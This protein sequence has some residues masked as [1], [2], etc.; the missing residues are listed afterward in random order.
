MRTKPFIIAVLSITS[1]FLVGH[2]AHS[3]EAPLGRVAPK[4]FSGNQL[5]FQ[6]VAMKGGSPYGYFVVKVDGEW[7]KIAIQPSN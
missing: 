2:L 7:T 4:I 6:M 3:Q 5:G 1:L